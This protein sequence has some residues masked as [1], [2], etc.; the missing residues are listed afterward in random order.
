MLALILLWSSVIISSCIWCYMDYQKSKKQIA[1]LKS[2]MKERNDRMLIG[3][4]GLTKIGY[5]R[6]SEDKLLINGIVQREDELCPRIKRC[7]EFN[8]TVWERGPLVEFHSHMFVY[9]KPEYTNSDVPAEPKEPK[10]YDIY[11]NNIPFNWKNNLNEIS[12]GSVV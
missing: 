1:E 7:L 9:D 11:K 5:G 3:E 8:R 4:A 12:Y 10:R 2:G 6:I